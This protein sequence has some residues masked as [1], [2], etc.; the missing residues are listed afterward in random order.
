MTLLTKLLQHLESVPLEYDRRGLTRMTGRPD[1]CRLMM[2]DS[3]KGKTLGQILNHKTPACILLM[4]VHGTAASRVGHFVG[5]FLG[6]RNTV[7]FVDPYGYD[8]Q[9]RLLTM[10]K[11]QPFLIDMVK[12]SGKTLVENHF[13]LQEK[14][15]HVETCMRHVAVRIR[16]MNMSHERYN[17]FIRGI[18]GLNPDQVVT[19][20]TF[21]Y[22]TNSRQHGMVGEDV[23]K[24]V[25][26]FLARRGLW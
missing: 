13:P 26:G 7:Q 6:P 23:D 19:L 24:V 8:L 10:T 20:L 4:M 14:T 5:M 9:R 22:P 18:E 11:S 12:E 1:Q 3:L 2:Y 25:G 15:D 17:K 16:M 21:F